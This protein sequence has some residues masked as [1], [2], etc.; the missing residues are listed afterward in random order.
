MKH[1]WI[2]AALGTVSVAA[3]LSGCAKAEA[4][5]VNK[6]S[7]QI[8]LL[9]YSSDFGL[10]QETRNVDL[11]KGVSTL[12][13]I[14]VS[15]SL[16]QDSVMFTWMDRKDAKVRSSTYDLG[17]EDSGRLLQR[18]LGKE[19]ELVYR[20]MNG[21]EGDRIKGTLEVAEPGNI[22]VKADGK[23]IVNPDATIEAPSDAGIVTIPQLTAEVES[24]TPGVASLGVSY[25]TGGLSWNADYTL[26][27][28][29]EEQAAN[30]ECWA[31]VRNQTGTDFPNAKLKFVAGSPNRATRPSKPSRAGRGQMYEQEA[32]VRAKAADSLQ[33]Q[34]FEVGEL[35]AYPYEASATIRQDQ[36][37]RVRMMGVDG[38]AV[39]RWYAI[40]LPT[41]WRD[42]YQG[43]P[44]Q[45]LTA[46]LGINFQNDEASKLGQ[47]MPGGSVRVYE[48]GAKGQPVYIGAATIGDTPKDA[49]VSL[50]LSNVFDVYA[51]GRQIK[52][53]KVGKKKVRKTVEIIVHNEKSS[54][55]EVRLVQSLY[56]PYKIVSETTK[57]VPLNSG[58]RQWSLQVPAG[59]EGKLTMVVEFM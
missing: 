13:L 1:G 2:I 34:S 54:A 48:P 47:P 37:N 59:G 29:K 50:T 6:E 10:V 33:F 26:T 39:K 14:D 53:E 12:G 42:G 20:S 18:F 56:G 49:K 28:P 27:L 15:K 36:I 44:E 21:R 30:M 51:Q 52:S 45:R 4:Q 38:V 58:L 41:L 43:N 25:L 35:H 16:D 46:T 3:S 8:E 40:A 23:Y 7:R 9:V 22:V 24:D 5:S 55:Q 57:S 17:L 32:G 19:V 11:Q 31:S